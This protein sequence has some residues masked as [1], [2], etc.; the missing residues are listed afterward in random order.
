MDSRAYWCGVAIALAVLLFLREQHESANNY[1]RGSGV[2]PGDGLGILTGPNIP[3]SAGSSGC[4][5][6]QSVAD[7]LQRFSAPIKGPSSPNSTAPASMSSFGN[8]TK[9]GPF[10]KTYINAFGARVPVGAGN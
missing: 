8:A 5:C 6:G 10:V 9:A 4:G 7:T 3:A 1:Y 2:T